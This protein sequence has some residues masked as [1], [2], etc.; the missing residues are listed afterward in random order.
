MITIGIASIPER[1]ENLKTIIAGFKNQADKINVY[2]DGYEN[3]PGFLNE[4]NID[5]FHSPKAVFSDA[6]KFI[7]VPKTGLYLSLDDDIDYPDNY[8]D[9]IKQAIKEHKGIV[10]YHGSLLRHPFISYYRSRV[11]FQ[12][13]K[14]TPKTMQVHIGGTGVM[15]FDTRLFR[16]TINIFS[17]KYMADIFLSIEAAKQN[18]S[19]FVIA[20]KEGWLKPLKSEGSILQRFGQNDRVQTEIVKENLN[21]LLRENHT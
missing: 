7:A 3:I 14:Y 21:V 16:P 8:I 17:H 6:G 13:N 10:T 18:M 19:I 5:V 9:E 4:N 12:F 2:L 11:S 20:H 15:G 1:F